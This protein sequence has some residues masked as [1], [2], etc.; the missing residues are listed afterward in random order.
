MNQNK[1]NHKLP[2]K[3][4][5][6]TVTRPGR[7][8]RSLLKFMTRPRPLT[9]CLFFVL[10]RHLIFKRWTAHRHDSAAQPATGER[11]Y[12]YACQIR[13]HRLRHPGGLVAV[14]GPGTF[15]GPSD[16]EP[17]ASS[18][19]GCCHGAWNLIW[20]IR[21]RT[22]SRVVFLAVRVT[23]LRMIYHAPPG[24]PAT[25]SSSFISFAG[26]EELPH[27]ARSSGMTRS[28]H[29]PFPS[30]SRM[31]FSASLRSTRFHGCNI[32]LL[33]FLQHPISRILCCSHL[34]LYLVSGILYCS[35]PLSLVSWIFP[36]QFL[37][38]SYTRSILSARS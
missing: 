23:A 36:L 29:H 1:L 15:F 7:T 8:Q 21:F 5:S 35:P 12:S 9:H 25:T 20:T 13:N 28:S 33:L 16:S 2:Y 10:I 24:F 38:Q 34:S 37:C 14:T 27:G 3:S 30:A 31:L 26:F 11:R 18:W 6:Q 22:R 4:G 32:V 17:S 19:T